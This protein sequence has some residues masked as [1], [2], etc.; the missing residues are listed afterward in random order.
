MAAVAADRRWAAI[1]VA[2]TVIMFACRAVLLSTDVG[3]LALVDQWE[4]TAI[5]FGN[6]VDDAAYARLHELSRQGVAYA[7]ITSLVSGPVLAFGL[8][9]VLVGVTRV[10]GAAA[11]FTEIL[12]VVSYAGVILAL[13]QLVATPFN[14]AL[15]TLASPTTLI[16]FAGVLDEGSAL[17][18]FLGVIDLFVVWWVVVLAIG[19]GALV[20]RPVRRLALAFA[21]AYVALALLLAA[22]MALT[23]GTA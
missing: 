7:A 18:R 1:L 2:T 16:R 8:S 9:L 20:H 4:R 6:T 23:G 17:A 3:R 22:V 13:R 10:L 5:A 15:E 12:A 19:I 14:Y 21:G 11:A